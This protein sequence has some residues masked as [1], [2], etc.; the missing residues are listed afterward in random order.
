[1]IWIEAK[2]KCILKEPKIKTNISVW[3]GILLTATKTTSFFHAYRFNYYLVLTLYILN[4]G[5][6]IDDLWWSNVFMLYIDTD[7]C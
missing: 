5:I 3:F 2:G 6:L 1:M 7:Y 4:D